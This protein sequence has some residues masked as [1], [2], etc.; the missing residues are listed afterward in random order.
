MGRRWAFVLQGKPGVFRLRNFWI[1]LI[2]SLFSVMGDNAYFTILGWFV[3]SVT[4]SQL[5][6]GTTMTFAAIPRIVFMLVGG[7]IADRISR[8]LIMSISLSL[9]AVVLFLFALRLVTGSAHPS[10][11]MI[12]TMATLFGVIDSFYYPAS[13]SV[14]QAAVAE[15]FVPR[16]TSILQTVQQSCTVLGPLLAAGLLSMHRYGL[17]FVTIGAFFACASLVV[18]ALRLRALLPQGDVQ[19]KAEQATTTS[20]LRDIAEGLRYVLSIRLLLIVMSLSLCINLLCTGPLNIGIP[21]LIRSRGWTGTT[22]GVYEAALGIGAVLGGVL[23]SVLKGFRGRLLWVGAFGVVMGLLIAL[24][25]YIPARVGGVLDMGV[26]GLAISVVNIP[27]LAFLQEFVPGDKLGRTMS[28]L[29]LVANGF[30]PISY[31]LSSWILQQHVP[32]PALLFGCGIGMSVVFSLLYGSREYRRIDS[33]TPAHEPDP[34]H[35]SEV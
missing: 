11:W 20:V 13:G 1:L 29:M 18:T 9:R 22:F 23:V 14:I 12:E 28:V 24:L 7:A 2:G 21:V 25:G 35:P 17:M 32:A 15:P 8:K 3:L 33:N 31:T 26:I 34:T 6:L 30:T 16:A 19:K 4:G 27:F 10:L 5:A